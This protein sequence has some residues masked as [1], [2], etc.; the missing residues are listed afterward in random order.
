MSSFILTFQPYQANNFARQI[1][2]MVLKWIIFILEWKSCLV[3]SR[4]VCQDINQFITHE[5]QLFLLFYQNSQSQISRL[6]DLSVW[7]RWFVC[8][9]SYIGGKWKIC[10]SSQYIFIF[11]I[12]SKFTTNSFYLI[13]WM[14][15]KIQW[16]ILKI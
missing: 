11:L 6:L 3:C 16:I 2:Q 5:S 10:R 8:S 12:F 13:L 1:N 4:S 14:N 7:F 15:C 9:L